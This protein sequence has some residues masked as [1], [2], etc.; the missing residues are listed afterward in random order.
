[1]SARAVELPGPSASAFANHTYSAGIGL[2]YTCVS[3]LYVNTSTGNDANDG[4][5]PTTAFKTI[6][7]ADTI[8]PSPGTCINVAPGTYTFTVPFEPAHGGNQSSPTGYVAYR[9]EMLDE[10]FIVFDGT[11]MGSTGQPVI[12]FTNPYFIFDGFDIDGG[13]AF[14][15][16]GIATACFDSGINDTGTPGHHIWVVNN[17]IHGCGIGCAP[18]ARTFCWLGGADGLL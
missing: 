18:C 17:N 2:L 10:C 16:G 5:T 4:L 8:I 13:E 15:F 11:F 6:Q 1:M 12:G 3:N 9:C 7:H 14:M